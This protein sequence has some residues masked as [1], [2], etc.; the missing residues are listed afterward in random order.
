MARGTSQ[1]RAPPASLLTD[2]VKGMQCGGGTSGGCRQSEARRVVRTN[3]GTGKRT[4]LAS[5]G[6]LTAKFTADR[7]GSNTWHVHAVGPLV[8]AGR[9]APSSMASVARRQRGGTLRQGALRRSAYVEA[10]ASRKWQGEH[11]PLRWAG[12][13]SP[14]LVGD[15]VLVAEPE[16]ASATN[17]PYSRRG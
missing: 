15:A 5:P 4:M 14:I 16:S 3:G 6:R 9:L 10:L 8:Q 11:V 1:S 2:P 17:A 7:N 12:T 13:C